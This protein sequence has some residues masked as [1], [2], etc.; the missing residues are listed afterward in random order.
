[1]ATFRFLHAADIHLD[2]PLHGLARYE[3]VPAD[4]VRRATRAAFDNLIRFACDQAVDFVVIAGDLFDGDWKDM[5]TGLYFARA[6][7]KLAAADIPVYLLAGN[8]DAA[9]VLTR[10]LPW[11]PN[12][13]QFGSRRAETHLIEALGVAIHGQSFAN[14]VVTENLAATYPEAV[15]HHFNIGLLHTALVG[16]ANHY[17]YAPCSID[18][19]LA[20]RYDYW[21]LGHV[22]D[23]AVH[24][25]QPHIVFPGNL[26][27]R[28]IRETGP[29]G[30]VLVDVEDGAV[31]ALNH[32]PLDVMRW[33]RVEV[34]CGGATSLDEVNAAI[35]TT[36]GRHHAELADGRP[37]IA[38]VVLT[39]Q[40]V[41]AGILHD[42]QASRR[43]E[44]RALAAAISPELWIE[45]VQLE[46][47]ALDNRTS[48]T[49]AP[50]DFLALFA[51]AATAPD[52]AQ[53]LK[54][55]FDA[56]LIA[57]AKAGEPGDR[58]LARVVAQGD[59][60]ALLA[61]AGAALGARLSGATD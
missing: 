25:E 6:M 32:V 42:S 23:H 5:G 17:P 60:P 36:L 61:T 38:R 8:H 18:D 20:K 27:G 28:H 1:M 10:Q 49:G 56:F 45:K 11:P 51:E 52:L 57:A 31:T 15:P 13:H 22:H 24:S 12:V 47:T 2:S 39:G 35:R 4:D 37:M 14:A 55:E 19:L 58:D 30:A 16:H 50:E 59:W 33:S 7:G 21:A 26:Q 9:S 48:L 29:K 3:G 44:A 53:L 41:L 43:D 40:T 54:E 34:D 46:V